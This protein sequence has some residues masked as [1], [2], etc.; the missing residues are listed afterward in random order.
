[1]SRIEQPVGREQFLTVSTNH[2]SS[3]KQNIKRVIVSPFLNLSESILAGDAFK[4]WRKLMGKYRVAVIVYEGLVQLA[5][6]Y[7]DPLKNKD[8]MKTKF[9]G[10]GENL[11]T[12][13]DY[14]KKKKQS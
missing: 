4:S 9:I 2:I 5:Q 1:M 3:F 14:G 10:A 7:F 13:Y 8:R 6:K 11:E 12:A